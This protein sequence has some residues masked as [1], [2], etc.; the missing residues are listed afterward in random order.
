MESSSPPSTAAAAAAALRDAE[1]SRTRLAHGVVTPPWFFTSLAVAIAAQIATTA[2]AFGDGAAWAL[3]AGL[4][5][6][7]AVA[8]VQLARFRRLNGVW[9]GGL[10]GRVVLGTGTLASAAYAAALAAAIWAAYDAGPWLVLLCS[11]AGGVAYA[12]GGGRWLRASRAQ[13]AVHGPGESALW[14]AVLGL[15]AVA[16]VVLLLANG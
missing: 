15:P 3:P 16:G 5:F 14:L 9:G 12:L 13:P 10:A 8:G 11:L 1:S 6:F 2:A 4:A 7:T